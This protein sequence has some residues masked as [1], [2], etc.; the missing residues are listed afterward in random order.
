[1]AVQ[2]NHKNNF[3]NFTLHEDFWVPDKWHF[4]ELYTYEKSVPFAFKEVLCELCQ[5]NAIFNDFCT[6]LHYQ[7]C[8]IQGVEILQEF[9]TVWN[10]QAHQ[11]SSKSEVE[12][13]ITHFCDDIAQ[14]D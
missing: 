6:S 9:Y 8:M 13:K 4:S 1:L 14:N 5:K 7:N 11:F 3:L 12:L 10:V 2:H